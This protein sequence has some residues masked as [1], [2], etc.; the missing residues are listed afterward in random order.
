M[1]SLS[2]AIFLARALRTMARPAGVS[3]TTH[4]DKPFGPIRKITTK[5]H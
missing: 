3:S 5:R 1:T 4:P 2:Q